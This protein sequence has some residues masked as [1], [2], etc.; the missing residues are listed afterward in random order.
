MNSYENAVQKEKRTQR[1]THGLQ[2]LVTTEIGKVLT[3]NHLNVNF[4]GVIKVYNPN[5]IK[6]R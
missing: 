4:R 6:I 2:K 3:I 1:G 5:A